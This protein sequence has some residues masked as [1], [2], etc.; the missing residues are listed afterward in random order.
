MP[1][2][3]ASHQDAALVSLREQLQEIWLCPTEPA[4]YAAA[5]TSKLVAVPVQLSDFEIL[6]GDANGRKLRYLGNTGIA[7][8]QGSVTRA[9]IVNKA[10]STIHFISNITSTPV[11]SG[12]QVTINSF[13]V[14]EVGNPL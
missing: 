2:V 13:D 9:V 1:F 5:N 11:A 14:W 10:T 4:S 6:P 7:T 8:A 12:G 3:H